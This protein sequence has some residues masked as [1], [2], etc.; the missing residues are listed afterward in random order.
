MQILRNSVRPNVDT[1]YSNVYYNIENEPLVIHVPAGIDRYFT[2]QFIDS[3][4]DNYHY[5][6][7]RTTGTEGGTYLLTGPNWRG[8]VPSNMKE[9]KSPTNFGLLFGRVVVNGPDDLQKAIKVQQSI[10]AAPLSVRQNSTT[11]LST[12]KDPITY[13]KSS[14]S[15]LPEHIPPVGAKIFDELAYYIGRDMPPANQS[16]IL[17]KIARLGIIPNANLTNQSAVTFNQTIIPVLLQGITNGEKLI[18]NEVT[19]FG[20]VLNG[21]AFSTETGKNPDDYLVRSAYAKYGLWGN[22]AVEAIY[23]ITSIDENGNSLDGTK[24]YVIHFAKDGLPPVNKGGF[25]SITLYNAKQLLNDNE[26]DRYV[27]NDRTQGLKYGP[28]GSLDIYLQNKKPTDTEKAANWLPTPDGPF[29]LTMR[30]YIP[31]EKMLSGEYG[32]PP[33]QLISNVV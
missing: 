9:I 27:I 16:N 30:V 19:V 21:W 33:V 4:T 7:T 3:Y 10:K 32:P 6:G 14:V 28:D 20:K 8:T 11:S 17:E 31:D 22:N 1:L 24:N 13:F 5:L 12:P 15:G 25:W 18:D 2:I 26:I 23:P 29:S